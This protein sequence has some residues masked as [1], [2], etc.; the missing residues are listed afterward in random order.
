LY[1]SEVVGQEKLKATLVDMVK[2]DHVGHSL[3]FTGSEGSGNLPLAIAFASYILCRQP[4]ETDRCGKCEACIQLNGLGHPDLHFSFPFV[5]INN[6][7]DTES[8]QREFVE[9]VKTNPYL[10]LKDWEGR[11]AG[12]NKQSIIPVDEVSSI[13]K[14]LSLKSFA[15]GYKVMVIWMPEKL[16][17]Q[18]ANKLLKT[19]EEPNSNTLIILACS[20]PDALLPTIISR[21]QI[22]KTAPLNDREV[23]K[24][25][26]DK[27]NI[28]DADAKKA[29]RVAE[30]DFNMALKL[31][32]N[33]ESGD[34]YF[35]LF[36]NWMRACV[37]PGRNDVTRIS[38]EIAGFSRDQQ[39]Y[40]LDYCLKFLHQ[41][42]IYAYLGA[43]ESKFLGEPRAFAEKFAPYMVS[44]DM[45][46]FHD[47]LSKAQALVER[48]ANPR[49]LYMKVSAEMIRIFKGKQPEPIS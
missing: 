19:L 28:S 8:L 29:A 24:G 35:E 46:A 30:G 17:I 48:N 4:G 7:R 20:N 23:E 33:P 1:F 15:G 43:E 16:R 40:F 39:V 26:V 11:I 38:E 47:V 6:L 2:N 9:T 44:R 12:E 14:K 3:L 18:G 42:L 27:V 49:L 36:R 34:A 5:K 22:F 21:M 32:Q 25:L 45:G 41:S 10:S 13:L 31:A 37:A